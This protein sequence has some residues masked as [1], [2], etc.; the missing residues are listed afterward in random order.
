MLPR[1]TFELTHPSN[2]PAFIH[3][4]WALRRAVGT[5]R[6]AV[7]KITVIA[8]A[9]TRALWCRNISGHNPMTRKPVATMRPN[10]RSCFRETSRFCLVEY[11]FFPPVSVGLQG[12]L[13]HLVDQVISEYEQ[14]HFCSHKTSIGILGSADDRFTADIERSVDNNCTTG[15][16]L[17]GLEQTVVSGVSVL[18]H[19]LNT[20]RVINMGHSG[21]VGPG[22]IQQIDAPQLICFGRHGEAARLDYRSDKQHVRAVHVHF[23]VFRNI[24]AQDRRSKRPE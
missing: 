15:Q 23:E 9:Q 17:K 6:P 12:F 22:D 13:I 14:I 4:W 8:K 20:C 2:S 24:L 10:E 21:N 1:I 18:V 5:S 19:S 7:P 11:K 3:I 16:C